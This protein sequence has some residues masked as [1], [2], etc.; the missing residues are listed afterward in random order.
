[1]LMKVEL[2]VSLANLM[3]ELVENDQPSDLS[4]LDFYQYH[5]DFLNEIYYKTL[6][7][8]E[9]LSEGALGYLIYEQAS[10]DSSDIEQFRAQSNKLQEFLNKVV[11]LPNLPPAAATWFK[12]QVKNTKL[13]GSLASKLDLENPQGAKAVVKKLFGDRFTIIKGVQAIAMIDQQA[14]AGLA[15]FS[16]ALA[17]LSRNLDGKIKPN[18]KLVDIE[19]DPDGALSKKDIASGIQKAFSKSVNNV[20]SKT[21]KGFMKKLGGVKIPGAEISDFPVDEVMPQIMELTM[22]QLSELVLA[23]PTGKIPDSPEKAVKDAAQAKEKP[24]EDGDG[25]AGAPEL[26]DDQV[27]KA[28]ASW[29]EKLKADGADAGLLKIG[30]DWIAAVSKDP[31]FRKLAGLDESRLPSMAFLLQEQVAWP[32]LL[33]VFTDNAPAAIGKLG[34]EILTPIIAPF[35]KAL[36]D[37]GVEVTDKNGNPFTPPEANTDDAINQ[38]EDEVPEAA[39]DEEENAET[40]FVPEWVKKLSSIEGILNPE[41]AAQKLSDIFSPESPE[42]EVVEEGHKWSIYDLLIEKVVKYDDVVKALSDYLPPGTGDRIKAISAIHDMVSG[43][44]DGA[45][46]SDIPELEEETDGEKSTTTA[47]ALQNYKSFRAALGSALRDEQDEKTKESLAANGVDEE[48]IDIILGDDFD[49]ATALEDKGFAKF[50]S[51]IDDSGIGDL[52]KV[53][54]FDSIFETPDAMAALEDQYGPEAAKAAT[55]VWASA[56]EEFAD[57]SDEDLIAL[58]NKFKEV[59]DGDSESAL[60]LLK[61]LPQKGL[62]GLIR[63]NLPEDLMATVLDQEV[64]SEEDGQ[65][66]V[67]S[68][69]IYQY[70]TSSGKETFLKVIG[71]N[72]AEGRK[73]GY[74]W[75]IVTLGKDGKSWRS[76]RQATAM[77]A[78]KFGEES[79]EATAFGEEVEEEAEPIKAD[80]VLAKV[81]QNPALGQGGAL[82]V[83]NMIDGGLFDD[84]GIKIERALRVGSLSILLEE[85]LASEEFEAAYE[86]AVEQNPSAFEETDIE[87]VANNLNDFFSE[88][89]I[90]IQIIPPVVEEEEAEFDPNAELD[91]DPEAME[92]AGVPDEEQEKLD[93]E[94]EKFASSLG[95]VPIDKNKLATILKKHPDIVGQGQKATRARRK[96]RKA[97]NV[98]AGMKVFAEAF[99]LG[100]VEQDRYILDES[101]EYDALAR[102]RKLAGIKDD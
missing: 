93:A 50:S 12:S 29:L 99:D 64:E 68:G 59:L 66:N 71:N 80:D 38:V 45:G 76:D 78:E 94:A 31:A 43:T 90:D 61:L 34:A 19:L 49:P 13:A 72:N 102:W 65:T 9:I 62:E 74:D 54:T 89:E 14:S 28:S 39:D 35:A 3:R 37:Q 63:N 53:L 23:I 88:N 75:L 33:K 40:D 42:E 73:E 47:A 70:T 101:R 58:S 67:E 26:T 84:M 8:D 30:Q 95:G 85:K 17:M 77:T 96:L 27:G 44:F 91:I 48:V 81:E 16:E 2:P 86:I 52:V 7:E 60:E 22:D 24:A 20:F 92:D 32:D 69:K 100:R 41:E 87:A 1:M 10:L 15:A 46:V 98:A 21:A 6:S 36:I 56:K 82:V 57:L 97:I 55:D 18:T 79:D 25:D 11:A 83:K 5:S 51:Q 4:F